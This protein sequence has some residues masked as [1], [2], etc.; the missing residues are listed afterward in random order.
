MARFVLLASPLLSPASWGSTPH[1]L[2]L[3]GHTAETPAWPG[4]ASI[5]D[6]YY[7]GLAE[8]LAWQIASGEPPIL[9]AHS[10]A[11]GLVP[12]VAARIPVAGVVFV[13]A[14][15]PHPG[16]SWFDTAPPDLAAQLRDGATEGKLPA[17]SDWWP[18]GA[19]ERLI[20][21]AAQREALTADLEPI[22]AAYFEEPAPRTELSAPAAYVRLSGSYEDDAAE[23]EGRGWPVMRLPMHHLGILTHGPTVA[24]ALHSA[25]ERLA[26]ASPRP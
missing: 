14:I 9:A 6:G 1:E 10:G 15:L 8:G 11:G 16:R 20:P 19:L 3:L 12:A 25:A 21:D 13:D 7:E 5:R 22:P 23:A 26:A 2:S 4:L 17:W 18:P 24:A